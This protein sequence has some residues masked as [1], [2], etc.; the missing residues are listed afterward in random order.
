[1]RKQKQTIIILYLEGNFSFFFS[2]NYYGLLFFFF[3]LDAFFCLTK[4]QKQ[5]TVKLQ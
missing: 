1:M 5:F 4:I 3:K 2:N